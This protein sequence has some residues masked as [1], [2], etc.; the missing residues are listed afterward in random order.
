MKPRRIDVATRVSLAWWSRWCDWR[1]SLIVVR[2]ETV[3]YWHRAGWRLLWRYKS[4]PGRPRIPLELRQLIRRMATDNPLWGEERIANELLLKLGIRVSPR[5]VRK[6]M[7]KRPPGRPRGDQRWVAFLRNHAKAIIA[8]DF[9]VAVTVDIPA[10]LCLR[11][12]P[13]R[14]PPS[15]ALKRHVTPDS[16]LDAATDEGRGRPRA[17]LPL[18]APR[19]GR[20]LR[21][22]PG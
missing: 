13:S 10:S 17:G 16:G 3:I 11:A 8:C 2:P 5:T 4:R 12:H 14:L 15:G 6:Y 22:T 7:P 18:S 1:S 20:H 19:S 9:F 21:E